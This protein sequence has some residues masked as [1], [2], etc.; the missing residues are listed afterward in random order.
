MSADNM[1]A[2]R[3][4][5]G[6]TGPPTIDGFATTDAGVI[7][8]EAEPGYVNGGRITCGTGGLPPV[9]IQSIKQGNTLVLG[10]SCRGD[11]SFDDIDGVIIALRQSGGGGAGPQRRVDVF[12]VWGDA[13]PVL[14]PNNLGTGYGAANPDPMNA[15]A[16]L[17]EAADIPAYDIRTNK[18]A[19]IG[20]VYYQRASGAGAWTQYSPA[21]VAD[22]SKYHVRVR[23][24]KPAVAPMTPEEFAWSIEVRIPID[25]AT[26]G[27]DWIDLNDDFGLFID[28]IRG[29]RINDMGDGIY[30]STQFK[31]PLNVP[32]LTGVIGA[33]TEIPA[34]SFGHGLKGGAVSQAEGVRIKNGSMGIGRRPAS[35]PMAALTNQISGTVN[36]HIVAQL[37]NTGP[38]ANGVKAEVRMANWGLPPAQFPAW[39][40]PGGC[41]NP[42]PTV[43]LLAGTMMAPA[44][45]ENVNNWP[46]ASVPAQYATHPHQCM[47]TQLD[48]TGVVTFS[49]SSARRNMDFV[50]LS[51]EVRDVEVSG[52]GYE[53]PPGGAPDHDFL[54]FTRCRKIVVS[55]LLG[56]KELDPETIV[57]VGGALQFAPDVPSPATGTLTMNPDNPAAST[58]TGSSWKNS[59]VYLWITEG[60]RRTGRHLEINGIKTEVLDNGPTDFGLAAHHEGISDNLNW[61]FSG[62]GMV[63]HGIGVYGLKV[64]HKGTTT[65]KVRVAAG[66]QEPAG[67]RSE[68]PPASGPTTGGSGEPGD[69]GGHGDEH[70][71]PK[72]CLA[73]LMGMFRHKTPVVLISAG[74]AT[75]LLLRLIA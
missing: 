47:W 44:N 41:Q 74:L 49:Q 36:N 23:S 64:P 66:P 57:L 40:P 19:H 35:D 45:G 54:L 48:A 22:T 32:D 33:S 43:N 61:A 72:G 60:F 75:P 11:T 10:I 42:S 27:G 12:P 9:I 65:I 1:L 8:T 58:T 51:E 29:Q 14:D 71:L 56:E 13:P 4:F 26:G 62:P 50:G 53:E 21:Q 5:D 69:S 67:D 52:E 18:P 59:V 25:T 30:V 28:V 3:D 24:W 38:A 55:E 16:H 37:E 2:F 34:G 20:P 73:A 17:F 46:A 39:N 31:F 15:G 6:V 63:R 7:T 70:H 68:L